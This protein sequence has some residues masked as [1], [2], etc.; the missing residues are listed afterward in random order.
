M[1]SAHGG[2]PKSGSLGAGRRYLR[3][4]NFRT[5]RFAFRYLRSIIGARLSQGKLG[6]IHDWEEANWKECFR[7]AECFR[8]NILVLR[9]SG[10]VAM[11]ESIMDDIKGESMFEKRQFPFEI[12]LSGTK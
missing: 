5:G 2:R 6:G 1:H 3:K 12:C 11:V 4:K 8:D 9:K 7:V 10:V